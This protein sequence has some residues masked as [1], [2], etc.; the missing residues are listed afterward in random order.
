MAMPS[1]RKQGKGGHQ[2]RSRAGR[3]SGWE[4]EGRRKASIAIGVDG[5]ARPHRRCD[6][7]DAAAGTSTAYATAASAVA[8]A[9]AAPADAAGPT[10]ATAK[11]AINAAAV[12]AA[13]KASTQVNATGVAATPI[14][15]QARTDGARIGNVRPPGANTWP[16]RRGLQ[17]PRRDACMRRPASLQSPR[18]C[19]QPAYR[20]QQSPRFCMRTAYRGMQPAFDAYEQGPV[21]R[22]G[23]ENQGRW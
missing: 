11:E 21:T 12:G 23:S 18:F 17:A 20:G 2:E 10:A 3:S 13:T 4:G 9:T 5:A 1:M 14:A 6:D 8:T 22:L 19:M 16:S 7:T 15:T